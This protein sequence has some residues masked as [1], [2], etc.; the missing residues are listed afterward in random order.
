MT[1]IMEAVCGAQGFYTSRS[2]N[3]IGGAGL[4]TVPAL[5]YIL[6]PT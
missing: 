4:G 2:G 1:N 6:L 3:Q 5:D